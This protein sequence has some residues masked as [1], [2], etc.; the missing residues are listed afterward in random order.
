MP[1]PSVYGDVCAKPSRGHRRHRSIGREHDTG[2]DQS[3]RPVCSGVYLR[4]RADTQGLNCDYRLFLCR[5]PPCQS[6]RL[7]LP[8]APRLTLSYLSCFS[9]S[10][11]TPRSI[12]AEPS[13]CGVHRSGHSQMISGMGYCTSAPA[14]SIS[15]TRLRRPLV[16]QTG[17]R[18]TRCV[19]P[20]N[21][22]TALHRTRPGQRVTVQVSLPITR[23][24]CLVTPCLKHRR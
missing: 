12:S 4:Q 22:R 6:S 15:A 18:A 5:S 8:F 23:R 24:T 19:I 9:R 7:S 10:L 17:I 14:M 21:G 11:S 3:G 2:M 20:T 13:W 16:R 1:I